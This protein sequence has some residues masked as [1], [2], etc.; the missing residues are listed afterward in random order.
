M[1]ISDMLKKNLELKDIHKGKRC[2]ILGNG[3][4]TDNQDLLFLEN[5]I[6]IVVNDIYKHEKIKEINPNYWVC[7]D[8]VY[9]KE[10]G[11][12]HLNPLINAVE[13]KEIHVKIFFPINY[14]KHQI[15]RTDFLNLHYL[16]L[17]G[18]RTIDEDINFA[19]EIPMYAQ[20][21]ILVAMMLA[22]HLGA[23]PIYLLGCD[24]TWWKF[25]R[26][27][28]KDSSV[29]NHSYKNGFFNFS[30]SYSYDF[31]QTTIYVQKFQYLQ[32]LKY[33]EKRGIQI[34]NATDG[35]YLDLFPRAKYEDLFP[36]AGR[37]IDTKSLL[38][39]M[40]DISSVLGKSALKLMNE[41]EWPSALVLL[42]EA[43]AQNINKASRTEGLDYLRSIC[44]MKLGERGEAI[45]AARQDYFCNPSN[46]ENALT[47]LK[48][49]RDDFTPDTD[50]YK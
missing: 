36:N 21:V 2:F 46:R 25:S 33:A 47:L 27:D 20:N 31:L 13:K 48:S 7:V 18:S 39:T 29:I 22:F 23:N 17:D 3:P 24:H 9:F 16:K 6:K 28:Y 19:Q 4:S 50:I 43:V 12:E 41:G 38:P 8:P 11:E 1:N 30:E 26:E 37:S 10:K 45:K 15:P 40:P 34:F 32:L 42:D 35:G 5:E 49:L 14:G 44:M